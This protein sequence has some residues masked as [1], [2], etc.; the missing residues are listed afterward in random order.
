MMVTNISLCPLGGLELSRHD[1][2]IIFEA[3][4]QGCNTTAAY[5]TIHKYAELNNKRVQI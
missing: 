1:G 4:S 2:S 5:I 3:L